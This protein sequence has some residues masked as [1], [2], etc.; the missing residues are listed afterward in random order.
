MY[1]VYDNCKAYPAYLIKFYSDGIQ[2][3]AAPGY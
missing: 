3:F 2:N 1:V